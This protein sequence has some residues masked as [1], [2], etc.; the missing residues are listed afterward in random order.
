MSKPFDPK[1]TALVLIDFQVGTLQL[2]KTMQSD[3]ALRN[4][5][6]L[7]KAA[8]AFNMPVV[9]TTSQEDQIQGEVPPSLARALPEAFETRVRRVGVVNAWADPKFRDAVKATKRKQLIMAGVTTDICLIFPSISAVEDGFEVQAVLDASGSPFEISE[10][11]SRRR[12]EMAG[13]VLTAT[14]TIIAELVQDW[15][16]KEGMELVPL[17]MA[18]SPMQKVA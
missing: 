7:A 12:M 11:T 1:N 5:V 3:L 4:A 14:N 17:M 18:A 10:Y 8:K 13:V 2:I 9:L 16:T 6:S 15:T